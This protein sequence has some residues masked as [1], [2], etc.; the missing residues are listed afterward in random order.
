[1]KSLPHASSA[2]Q[3][4][5]TEDSMDLEERSPCE[6]RQNA[7]SLPDSSDGHRGLRIRGS[8]RITGGWVRFARRR[9]IRHKVLIKVSPGCLGR[10]RR[11]LGK[12]GRIWLARGHN[13]NSTATGTFGSKVALYI[14]LLDQGHGNSTRSVSYL[15]VARPKRCK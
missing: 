4:A 13:V 15:K 5:H 12:A 2:R 6:G 3:K 9:M 11:V 8:I 14:P 10:G 1:M 7:V